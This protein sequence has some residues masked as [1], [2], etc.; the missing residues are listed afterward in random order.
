[1]RSTRCFTK[2]AQYK[3]QRTKPRQCGHLFVYWF[4]RVCLL[5]VGAKSDF[6]GVINALY[7]EVYVEREQ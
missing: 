4:G 6:V 7:A 1:M 5:N 3:T 2:L